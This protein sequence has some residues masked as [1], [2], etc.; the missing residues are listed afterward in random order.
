MSKI[1]VPSMGAESWR[2]FLAEP[3]RHWAI[4]YSARTLAHSWEAAKKT[5]AGLPPE[6]ERLLAQALGPVELLLAIPEHKTSLPGGGHASQSDV[7]ALVRHGGG[8]ASCTIEGKVNEPFGPTVGEWLVNASD[9]KRERLSFL[10]KTLRLPEPVPLEIRY[11]LLHRTAAALLEAERFGAD[12]AAMVVQSFSPAAMWLSDFQ[13]F[14][15][16]FGA[17][18]ESNTAVVTSQPG[19]ALILGWATG[20]PAFLAL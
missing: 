8:V 13:A 5:A 7:F 15:R 2:V 11:Q 19:K 20:D 4:G 9:G 14:V 16:L 1:V 10:A 17:E 6:V 12:H 3:E 18:T